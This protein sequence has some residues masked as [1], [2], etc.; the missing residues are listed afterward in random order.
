MSNTFTPLT[1]EKLNEALTTLLCP[2]ILATLNKRAPGHCMRIMDLDNDVMESICSELL[3]QLPGGNIYILGGS[4]QESDS[5]RITS[6]K[7][8]ELRN[9]GE[10]GELRPPLLVFIPPSLR[11][12][13]EDSFGVATFEELSFVDI[14][15]ELIKI[16]IERVPTSLAGFVSD[17]FSLA[18]EKNWP[19]GDNVARV[20]YLLTAL[21][22]GIDGEIL[23]AALY[24]FSLIPDFKL[25]EDPSKVK[26]RIN[27][28]LQSVELLMSSHKSVRAR[29]VDLGLKDKTLSNRLNTFFDHYD[30]HEPETWT[31]PITIE[32][33][34]WP[35]SFDK[36]SFL[37]EQSLDKIDLAVQET[38]LPFVKEDEDDA[39]LA[40]LTGQQVLIPDNR[41]KM[42]VTFEVNPHPKNVNGLDHF[43]VQIMSD[44]GLPV[45]KS[46]KVK[47]WNAKRTHCTT[48]L[49][50]L[51]K[52]D[53]E[54]G[55]HHIRVLPW[56]AEGDHIPMADGDGPDNFAI[57]A[58][59]SEPFYV[60]PGGTPV[61]EPPQRVTPYEQSVGHAKLKLQ[62]TALGDGRE[63]KD[64]ELGSVHWTHSD[65]KKKKTSKQEI[66]TARFGREGQV[67]ITVSPMLKEVE[68]R[69]LAAP[70]H[71][72]GRR[73][74]IN[75][76]EAQP[77]CESGLP[78]PS[79]S[80]MLSF[81]AA[82]AELFKAI[83]KGES[84]LIT[85]GFDIDNNNSL[86]TIYAEAYLDLVRGLMRQ[87][88]QSDGITRQKH[89]RELRGILAVDS[90]HVILED[91]R[92]K[93]RECV[94]VSPTH[95][96]RILWYQGWSHLGRKWI[97]ELSR[98]GKDF[99]P[100]LRNV[101]LDGIR[102]VNF[103]VGIPV[104]D[105]RT[106][107]PVD[108]IN[109]FWGLYAPTTEDNSRGLMA[110]VCAA[111][112]LPEPAS[113]GSDIS[114]TVLADK[115]ERY[116]S[117]HPYVRELSI[118]IF[119]PGSGAIIADALPALQ[120]KREYADLRYD[121]RLFTTDPE[122][123]V[124]GESLESMLEPAV[125]HKNE[126]ADAFA[127]SSGNHLFPKM[128]L[129]KHSLED[130]HENTEAHT[131]HISILLDLFSA[132]ELSAREPI[133]GQAPLY[134]LIQDYRGNFIDDDSG[135][136][137]QKSP[138][139]GVPVEPGTADESFDLL[140][141]LSSKICLATSAVATSGENFNKVPMLTLSLDPSERELIYRV[142]RVS[143]W[144]FTVDRNMGIEFFDHGGQGP[145]KRP[146]YLIDYIPGSGSHSTHNLIIS[147]LSTE[148][149][150]E[151][152][153]PV[154][155]IH[156]LE[157]NAGQ[158]VTILNHLRSLSGQLA[159]K[160]IS[161]PTQQMEALGLALARIYI[162]FQGALA[163]QI[164]VPLDAHTNLYRTSGSKNEIVDG[165]GLQRTDLALFDLNLGAR[166][167]TCN[168]V[169]VKCHHVKNFSAYNQLKE[170]I[171]QQIN[172]SERILQRHFDPA[173]KTPDRPDR[174]IK[175]R[176]LA[177]L[178][179][180]YLERSIRYGIF[181]ELAA[182]EAGA[183][184][185]SIEHGYSLQFLRSGL[186]FDFETNSNSMDVI[187]IENEV[188][189][190]FHRIGKDY[191]Q[192]LL[193]RCT[194]SDEEISSSPIKTIMTFETTSFLVPSRERVTFV[195]FGVYYDK[196]ENIEPV[197][198]PPSTDHLAD[199]PRGVETG[200]GP[201]QEEP[202]VIPEPVG[203][204]N[205][206]HE[207]E[208]SPVPY[209]LILGVNSIS[210]QYGILGEVA[211]R[212][213]ALDLNSPQTIS[214]FGVQGG[215]KSY[216]L[217]TIIEMSVM[218][219][220][221]VNMIGNP[222][223]TVIF[224]YSPTQD[225]T[226]EFTSLN[227]PN[228]IESEIAVLKEKYAANPQA[229]KDL[230]ILT[231]A[232]KVDE[233]R[234]EYPDIEVRPIAF[235]ASELK[236]SHW[237]FLMGAVGNQ[238]MYMRQINH[239]MKQLRKNLTLEALREAINA[240]NL[241]GHL[242]DTATNR[243]DFAAEYIDDGQKLQEFIR[244]GR[245]IIVD[246][247]DEYIEKD[248][249]L[250]LFMV[251]LQIFSE[252]ADNEESF[253]KLVVFD[254]AH[255]YIDSGDLV[256][257]LVEV[258]REM[259]HRRT[260]IMVASQDPPSVPVPLIEL[261][262]QIIM[263]K[264]NS[265]LWLKH[266]QKANASLGELTPEKMSRLGTGEAYVWSGKAGDDAFTRGAVKIK[267]RPRVTQH[268]GGTKTAIPG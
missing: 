5:K 198:H 207:E 247:R 157:A 154:L 262:T 212:K 40:G 134:G 136:F 14:Y 113:S 125:S 168:L 250:G 99:L 127:A 91:F 264:F 179:R 94:L 180:F 265:P 201:I 175:S 184:L 54:E 195:D 47:A 228:S 106:F 163:N 167:I 169:E 205:I 82:R 240:S 72:S 173:L 55:W 239:M 31:R 214:L 138:I 236:V 187:D 124:L 190:E 100:T 194:K 97:A 34:W 36:W 230:L 63:P 88:E 21:E 217:G 96:L 121:V 75:I 45:G 206:S 238:S 258:V 38:D 41:R 235:S 261:S 148:E 137:W 115:I 81:L 172:Q 102:A 58:Y 2:R 182:G 234:L 71:P 77:P 30:A 132:E 33:G 53:F 70:N 227:R 57:R 111:L 146:G 256:T 215:G 78:L 237:K 15:D 186:I 12:S 95:P 79:S 257:G 9:P 129:A 170:K 98:G 259:R 56:T 133:P 28:N 122:S 120:Q 130:F 32:K 248:E 225:Y 178:L 219:I 39:V 83:S 245:L 210:P 174:L 7:L 149:L 200:D 44:S 252:A 49:T 224:H 119:N 160:L 188:G 251:M 197:E 6:T 162:E 164:I 74:Q 226:P 29:I 213:V 244:P 19:F 242:K 20:R 69:I 87:A 142:H 42:S 243:L 90:V 118:N 117:Q 1:K 202:T 199:T 139:T 204:K 208:A 108:N 43:T 13:A 86:C 241:S 189:I 192:A 60:L 110:E 176:E 151:M 104:D 52:I 229:L 92:G 268:G 114:G 109:P 27:R 101:L 10:D 203:D 23:G 231:P 68:Q 254:E 11:T 156:D 220:K 161:T 50:K 123:P 181:E 267:C 232:N 4:D 223:A 131:A 16:L 260:S 171:T 135:T 64:I 85:Q 150:E 66:L 165:V 35:I 221:N 128:R 216:T 145:K 48:G 140:A 59:E 80:A 25:F 18:A 37:E 65:K 193:D 93:H 159:L 103:P 255:K 89:L 144:V 22:N 84:Q 222:L 263:H 116:L 76:G 17:I 107:V 183:F 211:G 141:L 152:L 73:M 3:R 185:D 126:A 246:L 209:D 253:N 158:A 24:E 266:I 51:D 155:R 233:R 105:G 112:D 166:V 8:V 218:S 191:I 62:L 46:K 177:L 61:E 153:K 249:A 143:D 147:S 26:G 196:D 67:Q